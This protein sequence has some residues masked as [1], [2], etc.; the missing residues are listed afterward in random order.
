MDHNWEPQS[1]SERTS[2]LNMVIIV[3]LSLVVNVLKV[4][5]DRPVHFLHKFFYVELKRNS[6]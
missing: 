2:D 3:I 1:S 4:Q 5:P 6:Y